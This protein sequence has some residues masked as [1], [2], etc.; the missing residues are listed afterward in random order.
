MRADAPL[1]EPYRPG[2][3]WVFSKGGSC[4]NQMCVMLAQLFSESDTLRFCFTLFLSLGDRPRPLACAPCLGDCWVRGRERG[5]SDTELPS[6][7]A[8]PDFVLFS[9]ELPRERQTSCRSSG[10][11]QPSW[12]CPS[13]SLR[14][15]AGGTR[16]Q[17]SST[18]MFQ[19][20]WVTLP[21]TRRHTWESLRH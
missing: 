18:F 14:A 6:G 17:Y 1:A 13:A 9:K 19:A 11:A 4:G 16:V 15:Q 3:P 7:L 2:P 12:T 20:A 10:N 5:R 8:K 21:D